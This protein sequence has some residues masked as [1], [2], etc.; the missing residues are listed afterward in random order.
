MSIRAIARDLYKA[1]QNVERLEQAIQA[2]H[3]AKQEPLT[4]ELRQARK[5]L[6]MIKRILE[7]EKESST[8]RNKF[9][10]FRR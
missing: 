4:G 7:G 5:E 1:Q 6:E 3:P 2:A 8:F 10:G 9:Q